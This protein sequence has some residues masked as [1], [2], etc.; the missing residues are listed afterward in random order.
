MIVFVLHYSRHVWTTFLIQP[1]Q[2]PPAADGSTWIQMAVLR[3][4]GFL[5]L[6]HNLL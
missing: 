4:S 2:A 3:R 1:V 6:L 5:V